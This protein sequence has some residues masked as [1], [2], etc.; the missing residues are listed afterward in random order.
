MTNFNPNLIFKRASGAGIDFTSIVLSAEVSTGRS[1]FVDQY[2]GK[3]AKIVIKNSSNESSVFN[4]N[5]PVGIFTGSNI[6]W[7]G[8][9]SGISYE[10]NKTDSS[11][12][13]ATLTVDDQFARL[14][15]VKVTN[16]TIASA[17]G[18]TQLITFNPALYGG[19]GPLTDVY[20]YEL[21]FPSYPG[22]AS[23][24][25]MSGSVFTGSVL[26]YMNKVQATENANM[27]VTGDNIAMV[28]R[29]I[30]QNDIYKLQVE[31]P[32][33]SGIFVNLKL[34]RTSSDTTIVYDS[35]NRTNFL[36][37][38]ANSVSVEPVGLATQNGQNAYSYATF[39]E[40]SYSRSTIDQTT[41][42]ALVL[43][44][45]LAQKLS[46]QVAVQFNISF[47][48]E[49]QNLTAANTMLGGV[50]TQRV[51]DVVYRVPGSGTDTT[52]TCVIEGA[53]YSFRPKQSRIT[54]NLTPL[55]VYTEYQNFT[56]DTGYGV[57]DQ[58][59]LG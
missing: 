18:S 17:L 7:R 26:D 38:F 34:G 42:Q 49:N 2:S 12:S 53:S 59:I 33:S 11:L 29:T 15:R 25:T 3:T 32:P 40:Y 8:R 31:D 30:M 58:D 13:T 22:T 41:A 4:I 27:I 14:G 1:N 20:F 48:L 54:L 10:D 44:K 5:H 35:F 39:G 51:L 55:A 28:S 46:D 23:S 36:D 56:L 9:V 19:S 21:G 6:F 47:L 37:F 24:S 16:R 52:T 43:A 50:I 45:N 57:L